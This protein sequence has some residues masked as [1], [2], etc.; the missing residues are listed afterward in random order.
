MAHTPE[1]RKRAYEKVKARRVAWLRA[2]GPCVICGSDEKLHVDHV[3]PLTKVSHNVWSW[4]EKRRQEELAKCQVL[5]KECHEDKT[6]E[7]NRE[8]NGGLR[9]GTETM[10]CKYK[11]RCDLCVTARSKSKQANREKRKKLGLPRQ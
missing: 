3:D 8:R 2:N 11:C 10:Y 7:E 5:C 9:H 4:S 6:A 1:S